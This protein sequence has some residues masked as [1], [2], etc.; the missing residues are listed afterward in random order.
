MKQP[1]SILLFPTIKPWKP[2]TKLC[3]YKL[4]H[5]NFND[6]GNQKAVPKYS[7]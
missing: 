6:V 5:K 3:Y 4:K 7:L 1:K 2:S